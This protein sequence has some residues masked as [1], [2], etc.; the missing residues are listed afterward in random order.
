MQNITQDEQKSNQPKDSLNR[1]LNSNKDLFVSKVDQLNELIEL[2]VGSLTY[3]IKFNNITDGKLKLLS[4]KDQFDPDSLKDFLKNYINSINDIEE[5]LHSPVQVSSKLKTEVFEAKQN[6]EPYTLVEDGNIKLSYH[7]ERIDEIDLK[8]NEM[9]FSF[10]VDSDT[11]SGPP[12]IDIL[13]KLKKALKNK[14]FDEDNILNLLN[15]ISKIEDLQINTIKN[16]NFKRKD[17]SKLSI[18]KEK[19]TIENSI[20]EN[21]LLRIETANF[22]L[23]NVRI[24]KCKAQLQVGEFNNIKGVKILGNNFRDSN[25]GSLYAGSYQNYNN[26]KDIVTIQG[27]SFIGAYVDA[28]TFDYP[29]SASGKNLKEFHKNMK[30]NDWDK[31]GSGHSLQVRLRKIFGFKKIYNRG[32]FSVKSAKSIKES[33]QEI[34]KDSYKSE[35]QESEEKLHDVY[36]QIDQLEPV[37]DEIKEVENQAE[38]DQTILKQ[39]QQEIQNVDNRISQSEDKIKSLEEESVSL[40][41]SFNPLNFRS[42]RIDKKIK[43][44]EA[45][46]DAHKESILK[47]T[48]YKKDIIDGHRTED[49]RK[50]FDEKVNMPPTPLSEIQKHSKFSNTRLVDLKNDHSEEIASFPRLIH[51][52]DSLELKIDEL[53]TELKSL[54]ITVDSPIFNSELRAEKAKAELKTQEVK[55]EAE[56][57]KAEAEK[58]KVELKTQEVKS[59]AESEK[60]KIEL[61]A[62]EVKAE[63]EK[64]KSEAEKAKVELKTQE[65]KAESEK[66]K[67]EAEKAKAE[68]KSQEVKSEAEKAKIELKAHE[69]KAETEKA[70]AETEKAK[71]ELKAHEVKAET[72]K[73]KAE[74]EKA[75]AEAE[76]A[77]TELKA[78]EVK[79]ETEKDKAE[80]EF[81]I[82]ETM[83]L[84]EREAKLIENLKSI[85]DQETNIQARNRLNKVES[86][87]SS[88][89]RE[90][91]KQATHSFQNTELDAYDLFNLTKGVSLK[92]VKKVYRKL[93]KEY[94]P[95][96]QEESGDI[97]QEDKLK[98]F[99]TI[100]KAYDILTKLNI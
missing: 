81:K 19:F 74:A 31:N 93:S 25:I 26:D 22:S 96:I 21:S 71:I 58:A 91:I 82:E 14:K 37:L 86:E 12:S 53:I 1:I 33:I 50:F 62:Q 67:S 5:V 56:K 10:K 44:N 41:K 38:A 94:H 23:T 83:L 34:K 24:E 13:S 54:N 48:Q 64:V 20:I 9:E 55:S 77:K 15:K 51:F 28:L 29:K 57:V 73:A 89:E 46:V 36:E 61:K 66:V 42:S 6:K 35:F 87:I 85:E 49:T 2:E 40:R 80:K 47:N 52:R 18:N 78:Q 68:L 16:T 39:V 65:V 97:S 17:L 7:P 90:R 4:D 63:S 92:E 98:T 59:E 32:E 72:E 43:F 8:I 30:L 3:R 88:K 76:K 70:K 60:A 84:K 27:N 75:K 45:Q 11:L 79:A 69:V 100:L 99:K 95:D